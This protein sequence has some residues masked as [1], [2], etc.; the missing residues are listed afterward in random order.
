SA[1][2]AYSVSSGTAALHLALLSCI[3]PG[4]RVLVPGFS[5]FASAS[6]VVHA[7]GIPVFVDVDPETFLLDLDDAWEKTGE[8][9]GAV[10]PVH[11]FGNVVPYDDLLEL[12]EEYDLRIVHDAAQAL[13]STYMGSELGEFNDVS[14]Y[15]FYPSKI[16][17]TGEGG[18]VTTN[19]E[20]LAHR[21][22]LFK[23]HGETEK[24]R[25]TLLGYNYR[26]NE[27]AS[28]IGL[29]QMTRLDY[30]LGK[31]RSI[32]RY[33]DLAIGN[34]EGVMPQRVTEGTESCYNYY[35]VRVDPDM[36]LDRDRIVMD[37]RNMNI[38]TLVHY[39]YALTEQPAL[40]KYVT[41]PCPVA[42]ELARNVFSIPI[43]PYL[44]EREAEQVVLALRTAVY[45]Y[46]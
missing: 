44:S 30:F 42:E 22:G 29:D 27:I 21:V 20:E 15:S 46:L 10:V 5:F 12:A 14:C 7:G 40:M 45:R 25:H 19:S 41:E 3:E 37:M 13:G 36:G 8:G 2:Y 17:T 24:Y 6:A 9:I 32:A 1:Q 23:N 38:E 34:I 35:T 16:I 33:Y 18:M 31:R 26:G 39:P 11:L 28:V 43:H 4:A